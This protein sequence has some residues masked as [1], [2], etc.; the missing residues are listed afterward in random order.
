[1]ASLNWRFGLTQLTA[2]WIE[3]EPFPGLSNVAT[4]T[5]DIITIPITLYMDMGMVMMP[6]EGLP[7]DGAMGWSMESTSA[8][9]PVAVAVWFGL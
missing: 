5:K 7:R 9:K 3:V 8:T 2:W 4:P 6:K 1:V